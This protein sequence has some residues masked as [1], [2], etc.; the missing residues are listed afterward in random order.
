MAT[1][2]GREQLLVQTRLTL[3]GVDPADG[4]VLFGIQNDRE[5]RKFCSDV[6]QRDDLGGVE[7]AAV[8]Q[9]GGYPSRI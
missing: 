1:L 9:H 6:L 2:H 5:W 3:A 7:I 4:A 8:A